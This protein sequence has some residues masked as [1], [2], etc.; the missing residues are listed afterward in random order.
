MTMFKS[1]SL[2]QRPKPSPKG[3]ELLCRAGPSFGCVQTPLRI[4]TLLS[5]LRTYQRAKQAKLKE[6]RKKIK[7]KKAIGIANA[8]AKK[9]AKTTKVE[10]SSEL[11]SASDADEA[12]QPL[13]RAKIASSS[14]RES[15]VHRTS[16]DAEKRKL[17]TKVARKSREAMKSHV[18]GKSKRKPQTDDGA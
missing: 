17:T 14:A 13:K 11:G 4:F 12:A 7:E 9:A 15:R 10:A 2:N 3:R 8:K 6:R 18:L 5:H 1:Y 16:L